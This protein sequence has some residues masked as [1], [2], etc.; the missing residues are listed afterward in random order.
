MNFNIEYSTTL[1]YVFIIITFFVFAIAL[2]I[3]VYICKKK[4][5]E[6]MKKKIFNY[7][8]QITQET[9]K[10]T[11][12]RGYSQFIISNPT[13]NFERKNTYIN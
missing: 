13:E 8:Q 10:N 11:F 6:E 9:Y 12:I 1:K 3:G 2:A 5:N 7:E 4:Q